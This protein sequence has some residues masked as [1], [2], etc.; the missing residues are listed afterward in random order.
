MEL[1]GYL[2]NNSI[3]D[4]VSAEKREE[5]LSPRVNSCQFRFE[6]FA[7]EIKGQ[8][9][10]QCLEG[11]FAASSLH[12]DAT[13][14]QIKLWFEWRQPNGLAT[15]RNSL[16]DIPVFQGQSKAIIRKMVRIQRIFPVRRPEGFKGFIEIAGP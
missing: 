9:F 7:L 10:T 6:K 15:K 3:Q 5:G 8:T 1:V 13:Q 16:V 12:V 11:L 4:V 14:V 2:S